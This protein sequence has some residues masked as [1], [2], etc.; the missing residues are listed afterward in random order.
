[1]KTSKPINDG[2]DDAFK[3]YV[4]VRPLTSRE[5]FTGD[6]KRSG[7]VINVVEDEEE[8]T[9]LYVSDPDLL[10][11]YAGRKERGYTFDSIFQYTDTNE[12]VFYN[13]ILP[14]LPSILEGYN[15]TWFAYGM[16]GSGKTHTMLGDIYNWSTQEKGLCLLTVEKLFELMGEQTEKKFGIKISYLEIYNEHV[17]DLL[18]DRQ[19]QLMIVE[20]PVKGVFVPELREVEVSHPA[21]LVD[22]IVDGNSRRTMASTSANQFS[23]RSHAILQISIQ[24]SGKSLDMIDQVFYSKLS[25]IDLAGSERAA[26]TTNRGQRMVEGANINKSLLALGNCI[27]ILSDKN[28]I[29]SFV[30]Y[31]DSKLTRLLKDSLGGNTKTCMI[32]CIS[33]S[34]YCYEESIN[35]LKYAERAKNIKKKTKRNIRDVEVHMSKYKEI[36]DSLKGEIDILKDQLKIEQ[37]KKRSKE[38]KNFIKPQFYEAKM[39]QENILEFIEQNNQSKKV[40][41]HISQVI[42]Q[43]NCISDL[44]ALNEDIHYSIENKEEI[45]ANLD[46][47][48]KEREDLE[49]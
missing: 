26:S 6:T 37:E 22:M 5:K 3:V 34:Y 45:N 36:I 43:I 49:K 25:L 41:T 38:K 4:R 20:D 35:T 8:W 10:Y 48:R 31:R 14:L 39:E 44:S 1:M 11:D 23:S 29:G 28:K 46:E 15:A 32:A 18:D 13:T 7:T 27:N 42:D 21:E 33:P 9:K 47:V 40:N 16:T 2:E 17:R 24:A 30:P 19:T 12:K